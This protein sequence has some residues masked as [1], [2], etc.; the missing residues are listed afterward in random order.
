MKKIL[1]MSNEDA[2]KFLLKSKSYFSLDLPSYFEFGSLLWDVDK[3][4]SGKDLKSFYKDNKK[5]PPRKCEN[6]NYKLLHNKDGNFDWRP[7][8]I[9]HPVLYVALVNLIC[10]KDN[11]KKI[12]SRF[13]SFQKNKKII[14][15]SIP[16]ESNNKET[17]KK[18]VILNW[19]NMFEQKS[20]AMSLKYNCMAVTDITNCYGS[21]YT[22]SIAWAIET[23]EIAKQKKDDNSLLGNKIDSI[24]QDMSYGQTNGLPQGSVLT[25][26]IAEILLGYA[27][28]QIGNEIKKNKINKYSILRYRDDYRIYAQNELEL[29]A[30]LRI[31]TDVLSTLNF[32][33][34]ATKTIITT[35]II[36]YSVKKDKRNIMSNQY[37]IENNIQ[38]SLYNIRSFSL[39]YPNSGSLLN[40]LTEVYEKQIKTLK[41]LPKDYEQIISILVDIM[42]R[43]PRTYNLCILILSVIFSFMRKYS[44]DKYT[45]LILKKFRNIPNTDYL[46]IWLQRLT[47]TTNIEKKY[48]CLLC[49]KIYSDIKL[50]NSDWLNW[51][52]DETKIL[53]KETIKNTVQII[54]EK[55]IN[56]FV[57]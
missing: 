2:K 14:C 7:F 42:Y 33:L 21:I 25:D 24:I 38:K 27:D 56:P 44:I 9:I 23:K 10:E 37:V 26:F 53:N 43:N 12:T 57:Y 45:N 6:V 49:K 15:C 32:K 13:N 50:W 54:P 47:L 30:I 28:E 46:E 8:E 39:E 22:H 55:E 36:S 35:D 19:W 41:K 18:D 5:I 4:I 29:K 34:N 16:C 11:W 17:D 52:F 40:L 48:S 31:I 3:K 1:H 51:I 20:I